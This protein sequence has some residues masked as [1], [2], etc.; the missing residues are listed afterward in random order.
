MRACFPCSVDS[1]RVKHNT[2]GNEIQRNNSPKCYLRSR[3]NRWKVVEAQWTNEFFS[4][5]YLL[6]VLIFFIPVLTIRIPCS[7]RYPKGQEYLQWATEL[8]DIGGNAVR[9]GTL[10]ESIVSIPV[11]RHIG[12]FFLDYTLLFG[13]YSQWNETSELSVTSASNW[14]RF[15]W[16]N[17]IISKA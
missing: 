16:P 5:T 15:L 12:C 3:L 9:H 1:W 14:R 8:M 4:V 10:M 6:I 7:L 11:L 2:G 17:V 13:H